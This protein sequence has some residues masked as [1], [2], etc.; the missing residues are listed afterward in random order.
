MKQSIVI[1]APIVDVFDSIAK[2]NLREKWFPNVTS[3]RY[4]HPKDESN[5][6]ATF[7]LTAEEGKEHVLLQGRN[8]EVIHP[9][10]FAFE[11]ESQTYIMT[12]SYHLHKKGEH[13]LVDQEF[14]T[15]YHRPFM[16]VIDK[17]FKSS[18]KQTGE[19]VLNNLENFCVLNR[20]N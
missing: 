20:S 1:E 19:F 3:I 18:T 17:I 11:I 13:T 7:Q 2:S 15:K 8:K 10:F 9:S 6:G 12:F 4:S 16:N 5:T 14:E